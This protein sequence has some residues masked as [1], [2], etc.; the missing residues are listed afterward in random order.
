M[1]SAAVGSDLSGPE[2]TLTLLASQ[3]G[4]YDT[5]TGFLLMGGK[6]RVR[7]RGR[8]RGRVGKGREGRKRDGGRNG[9]NVTMS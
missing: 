9:G 6:E 8:E 3:F 7:R 4:Q 2:K 1:E 5:M